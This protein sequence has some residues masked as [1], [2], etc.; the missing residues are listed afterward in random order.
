MGLPVSRED[1]ASALF[2]LVSGSA[3][4][5]TSSRVFRGF[6]EV[7]REEM[8]AIFQIQRP[9]KYERAPGGMVGI[10]PKRTMVFELFL[11]TCDPQERSVP[12]SIQMNRMIDA[13]ET[14]LLPSPTTGLQTLGGLVASARLEGELIYAESLTTDNKSVAVLQVQVLRP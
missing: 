10:P 14:S 8:P 11:Y 1:V 12:P 9:E 3:G 2:A 7:N 4:M 5:V 6:D 13:V